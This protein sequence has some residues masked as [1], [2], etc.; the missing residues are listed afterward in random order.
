MGASLQ[1]T[2]PTPLFSKSLCFQ[3]LSADIW[4][5]SKPKSLA[6]LFF[7]QVS[8]IKAVVCLY[9]HIYNILKYLQNSSISWLRRMACNLYILLYTNLGGML[10]KF[11]EGIHSQSLRGDVFW[12]KALPD[13]MCHKTLLSSKKKIWSGSL[14][15][16]SFKPNGNI[17]SVASFLLFS[18]TEPY[19]TPS[20]VSICC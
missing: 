8:L 11:H 6:A 14:F 10:F 12:V 17:T 7:T 4:G 9:L 16:L 5:L 18:F 13:T 15:F 1:L 19:Y 2:V 20:I 3:K